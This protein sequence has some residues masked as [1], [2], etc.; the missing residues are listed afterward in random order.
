M[1]YGTPRLRRRARSRAGHGRARRGHQRGRP[2]WAERGSAR[3]RFAL[4]ARARGRS[5]CARVASVDALTFNGRSPG[6][7]L[8]VRQGDLV[9]VTLAN[10]DV[11]GGV[12]DPLA[13]RRRAERRGR[14]RRSDAGRGPPRRALHLPLPRRPGRDV[15]VPHASGLLEGGAARAVRRF[16]RSSRATRR[17]TVSTSHSSPTRS[18]GSRRSTGADGVARRAVRRARRCGSGSINTDST[19]QRFASRNAVPRRRDRRHRRERPGSLDGATLGS[20]A[21]GR[22]DVAFTMPRAPVALASQD[23]DAALALERGRRRRSRRRRRRT[24]EFDPLDLRTARA[25]AVR[26]RR[27]GSTAASPHDRDGSSASST[28]GRDASGR[29]TGASTPMSRCSSSARATSS[30]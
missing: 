25:D 7:E 11:E 21:G 4:T 18:T 1:D 26:R 20:P 8:R 22:Y 14:G 3:R 12:H 27:A 5:G 24:R 13:R 15:L 2:A 16:R 6:P 23:T 30:R 17:R 29:S 28:G 19:P 10:E 9:E